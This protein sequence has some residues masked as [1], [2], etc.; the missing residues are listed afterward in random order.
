MMWYQ[1]RMNKTCHSGNPKF[2]L[3]CGN[4]KVELPLLKQPSELLSHLMFD[5]DSL[6]SRKF[7]QKIRIYNM[8]F[9]FTSHGGKL[10][11]LFNKGGG[12]PTLQIQGQS[13]HQIGS[14]LPPE[15]QPP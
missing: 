8:M 14:L 12:P 10:D 9:A 3:C 7:Q 6:V 2:N 1:E 5:Q 11:N 13:C 4:V 15:G